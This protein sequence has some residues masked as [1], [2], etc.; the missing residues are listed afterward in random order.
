[1]TGNARKQELSQETAELDSSN[2]GCS[3]ED[4]TMKEKSI[5]I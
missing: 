1:M 3:K 2:T 4:E 5:M